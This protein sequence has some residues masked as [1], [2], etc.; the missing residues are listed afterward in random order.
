M[1]IMDSLSSGK[2]ISNTRFT[3][4]CWARDQ[5]IVGIRNPREFDF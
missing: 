2:L 1:W 4:W 5:H 3:L